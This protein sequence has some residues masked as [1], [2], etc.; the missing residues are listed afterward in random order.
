[1]L[2]RLESDRTYRRTF[3]QEDLHV[4]IAG[5][6]FPIVEVVRILHRIVH[7]LGSHIRT[8]NISQRTQ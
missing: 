7:P 2:V 5:I 8:L 3:V 4:D 1:V 6:L